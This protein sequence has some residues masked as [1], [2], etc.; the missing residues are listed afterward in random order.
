[1]QVFLSNNN[2]NFKADQFNQLMVP[3]KGKTTLGQSGPVSNSNEGVLHTT[4][5]STAGINTNGWLFSILKSM[6][7]KKW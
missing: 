5:N 7:T 3:K 1:M 2:N 4:P 6:L